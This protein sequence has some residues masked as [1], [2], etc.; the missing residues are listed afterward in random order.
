[1]KLVCQ[2]FWGLCNKAIQ[3]KF[4]QPNMA[5]IG[6]NGW[7]VQETIKNKEGKFC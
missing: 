6:P 7:K 3:Y 4:L 2:V 5:S 1:M